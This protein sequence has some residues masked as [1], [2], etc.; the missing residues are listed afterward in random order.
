M[1]DYIIVGAG[2]AGCVLANRLSENPETSV[3]LLEAGS[4]DDAP[5]I[6][7]PAAFTSLF[8]SANDWDYMTEEEPH[9]NHRKLHWPRGKVLGGTSS[10]NAM[11]YMRGNRA[12]YDHWQALGNKGWGY[13]DVLPYF[14]KS[15]HQE[16]GAS[17]YHGVGGPLNVMDRRY[18]NPLSFTF[19]DAGVELGW[20]HNDD[21]NGASQEG[22]GLVQV[23]QHQG[24]RHSAAA[25]YLHPVLNRPNLTLKTGVLVTRI[26]FD[27]A[28]A[29]GVAYLKDGFEHQDM[30]NNEVL[31]TA[32]AINSPHLL[33]LSGVGPANQ[34]HKLGIPVI[35][36][37]PGVGRNLQDHLDI[38]VACS[39][40]QPITFYTIQT[41]ENLQEFL[42]HQ[43]GPF[44]S[45]ISEAGAFVK[46]RPELALPDIEFHWGPIL[47]I[48]NGAIQVERHAYTFVPTLVTPQ[49]RGHLELRSSDPTVYP[50]IYA[51]Y[52]SH[53]DDLQALV[54]SVKMSRKLSQTKAFAPFFE[55]ELYPGPQIQSDQEIIEYIRNYAQT[56]FHPVGT[57]KMGHDELAVVD[58]QLRVH[59]T[60]G[61][62]V[63]D[64]SIMPT[65]PNGNT[66]APVIMIAEKA[67]DLIKNDYKTNRGNL[68]MSPQ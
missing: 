19:V 51:N 27:G 43:R 66:N 62:R 42:H 14:K 36:D 60:E 32:G 59:G 9:L 57:C 58:S 28:R 68:V 30:V 16:R 17:E 4:N 38:S 5:E 11:I 23:T 7:M 45:N 40:K 55:D 64:A 3:L 50:A 33:L 13:V 18:T 63:V 34:M 52:L 44:T 48:H 39:S 15:E 47:F 67:A 25:G 21:F 49:S 46:T 41:E 6:H 65:I 54:E 22:F 37:L 12:N 56:M 1:F 8:H 31:L 10:I 61:L 29:V 53:E 24:K 2:S 35:A 26:L 20:S